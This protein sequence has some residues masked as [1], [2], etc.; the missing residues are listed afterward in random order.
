M[1][2]YRESIESDLSPQ[3]W[4]QRC[5][6]KRPRDFDARCPTFKNNEYIWSK[7]V[8][9]GYDEEK[10]KFLVRV[11]EGQLEKYVSRTAI[12]FR[13]ENSKSVL[14]RLQRDQLHTVAQ[15]EYKRFYEHFS[16]L[17]DALVGGLD[18]VIRERIENLIVRTV[19]QEDPLLR[20]LFVEVEHDFKIR[21]KQFFVI[22]QMDSQKYHDY[23]NSLKIQIRS[24][25]QKQYPR[26]GCALSG[27]QEN[28]RI[29]F[30]ILKKKTTLTN[31]ECLKALLQLGK[32]FEE[33]QGLLVLDTKEIN[34]MPFRLESLLADNKK[35]LDKF[36]QNINFLFREYIIGEIH[37]RLKNT[38]NFYTVDTKQYKN[39]ELHKYLMRVTFQI[40]SFLLQ[41]VFQH[42][43]KVPTRS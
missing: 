32:K 3:E 30:E 21:M 29:T 1:K 41:N 13:E 24:I 40:K 23:Y 6:S 33:L 19:S 14:R 11:V 7:V 4:L 37:D 27:N 26:Q 43:C 38:F 10:K 31:R 34:S 42:S 15:L 35:Q 9:K 28:T 22:Q 18:H 5:Q 17:N 20:D 12:I 2:E 36:K 39:S 16:Q 25:M 8:V